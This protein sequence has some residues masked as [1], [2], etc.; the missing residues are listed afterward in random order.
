MYH[1][2][3]SVSDDAP[4][5]ARLV[6]SQAPQHSDHLNRR[7]RGRLTKKAQS[8]LH[9]ADGNICYYSNNGNFVAYCT[10]HEHCILTRKGCPPSGESRPM[11]M[12]CSSSG[13]A[14]LFDTDD[15]RFLGNF[16]VTN[17]V[18]AEARERLSLDG[19]IHSLLCERPSPKGIHAQILS[20][21]NSH[22]S[23]EEGACT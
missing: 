17:S 8:T 15:H 5:D 6:A 23:R 2:D 21:W 7:R 10:F 19:G 4:G 3:R 18:A 12:M 14:N 16:D 22:A 9:V 11:R 13:L 20:L 1:R